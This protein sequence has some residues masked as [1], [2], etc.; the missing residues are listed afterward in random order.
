MCCCHTRNER[1]RWVPADR[2]H[3]PCG[4]W[5]RNFGGGWRYW[6]GRDRVF[7]TDH[8]RAAKRPC[9]VYRRLFRPDPR[10]G[11]RQPV[12]GEPAC[13]AGCRRKWQAGWRAANGQDGECRANSNLGCSPQVD[14][15][16]HFD[17]W[18]KKSCPLPTRVVNDQ[19]RYRQFHAPPRR[20]RS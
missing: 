5:N 4:C 7:T 11:V 10:V 12:C 6:R 16:R 13:Q 9:S 14:G 18:P 2:W 17:K 8:H 20:R 1:Y 19:G 3:V 15:K